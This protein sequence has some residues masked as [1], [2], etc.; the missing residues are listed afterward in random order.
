MKISTYCYLNLYGAGVVN[1]VSVSRLY[2]SYKNLEGIGLEVDV[3]VDLTGGIVVY[4]KTK[5]VTDDP[6][7]IKQGREELW[8]KMANAY[9]NDYP[10]TCATAVVR[11]K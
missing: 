2:G 5:S 9:E 4:F 3:M 6:E 1:I 8:N 11:D 10:M 7:N